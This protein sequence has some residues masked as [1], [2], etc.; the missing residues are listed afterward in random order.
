[1]IL[2]TDR[3]T[4]RPLQSTDVEAVASYSTKP[5]FIRFLPLPPQ[6]MESAAE[7]VGQAV[8]NGQP[9]PKGDWLFAIQIREEPR[10]IGIIRIGVRSVE[11]RQGDLGYAVHPDHWGKGYATEALRR[12]LE[13]GFEDLSLER[14]WATADIRNVASWRVMEKAGMG[15]EGFMR[16][17]LLVRGAW[18]DSVL[19][20]RINATSP[21]P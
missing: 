4:L 1:M 3:L 17:H 9:D 21:S 15:R 18:R 10:L 12:I 2:E 16:H 19:Y 20:A 5:E 6:T 14:I 8:A 7:F 11:H 13:F